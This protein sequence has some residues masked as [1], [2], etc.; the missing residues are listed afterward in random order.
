MKEIFIDKKYLKENPDHIFV[1][2]DN[3]IRMG[4]GGAA[5]LRDVS[6]T[7]G[8]ITKIKPWTGDGDYYKP[9][10]Y[11]A[12]YQVELR[13]LIKEIERNPTKTYLIS[14]LGA[15]LANKFNIF[16]KVI[17]PNIKNDLAEYENVKFLW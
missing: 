14:K 10:E 3:T 2:G 15:G 7:Y 5:K 11:E 13:R 12:K 1:F 17:E 9:N 4:K 8:F 6:N 16:D